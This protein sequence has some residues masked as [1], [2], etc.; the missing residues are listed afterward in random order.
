M[1]L[2]NSVH[3]KIT[4]AIEAHFFFHFTRDLGKGSAITDQDPL[5][6][7]TAT[8]IATTTTTIIVIII[9]KTTTKIHD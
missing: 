6:N 1:L 9:T 7:T 4:S 2:R 5:P 8:T 3:Y